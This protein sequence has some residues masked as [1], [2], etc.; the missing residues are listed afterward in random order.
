VHCPSCGQ[1]NLADATVCDRC[2]SPLTAE[3][4]SIDRYRVQRLLGEG[5]RKRVY[6]AWD[7]RLDRRVAL[8][9]VQ[10]AVVGAEELVRIRAEARAMARLADH[11]N[12]VI[13]H[14][15][16]EQDG[17][18]FIVSEYMAGGDL[19]GLLEHTPERRL[20]VRRALQIAEQITRALEYAH[21]RGIV[22]RDLK[23]A[24]VWLTGDG[25]AKLGDFGL[26]LGT[27]LENAGGAVAGTAAYMSPEQA[28]GAPVDARSDLYALG[29][30]LYE[31]VT[32]RPP[33]EADDALAVVAQHV[34]SAPEPPAALDERVPQAVSQLILRLLA[35]SPGDRPPDA[36]TVR[37]ELQALLA[38]GGSE[39][40][41]ASA[42]SST[43]TAEW[44][45]GASEPRPRR[46]W[47]RQPRGWVTIV[48][49]M[50]GLA[51]ALSLLEQQ[52][53]AAPIAPHDTRTIVGV[54]GFA[55]DGSGAE[56]EWTR[57]VTRDSLNAILSRVDEVHVYA[58]EMIDFKREKYGLSEIEVAQELG[59]TKM[60]S[61]TIGL[62]PSAVSVEVRLVDIR[63]GFL[64]AA[65]SRQRPRAELIDLQNEIAT[66]LLGALG[67]SLPPER[68]KRLLGHR[69][70][71]M[72]ESY[73]RF[74]DALGDIEG[75]EE[76][77]PS[78]DDGSWVPRPW[79]FAFGG[80]AHAQGNPDEDAI[81]ALLEAYRVALEAEDMERLAHLHL[82][83]SD[84]QRG[85]L[86][87]YFAGVRDLRVR[88]SHID[89]T[90]AGDEALV[91]YTREDVFVDERSGRPV[92]LDTR[93]SRLLAKR[94]GMWKIGDRKDPS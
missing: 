52:R 56:L 69:Q 16:G 32:G 30:V 14:D 94:D 62:T 15:T 82:H 26:A 8:A 74:Y 31:M 48:I 4:P 88:L 21:D 45:R 3:L 43:A 28:L 46:H 12:V 73:Q 70:R 27:G 58:K 71:E 57:Q 76:P 63:T 41:P 68:L 13:V 79:R 77:A 83:M 23:P 7:T 35:K 9:V 29:A 25:V 87:R 22:H 78:P 10:T 54:M 17:Q 1:A 60:V 24:N 86:T 53:S 91:S 80:V 81:R 67:V 90:L 93:L 84:R 34:N 2:A 92:H 55:A 37:R 75:P 49:L 42:A 72:L 20:P 5:G 6:L 33:F 59:I 47:L 44:P 85:G 89:I 65:I 19:E 40:H 11:P 38:A 18:P 64:E 61:G 51:A 36:A 50:L 39:A 66:A